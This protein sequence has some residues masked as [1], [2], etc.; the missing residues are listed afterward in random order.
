MTDPSTN[1]PNWYALAPAAVAQ[2]LE[3]DPA[4][5]LSAV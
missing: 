1:A 5:G 4:Q 3:V 2:Q